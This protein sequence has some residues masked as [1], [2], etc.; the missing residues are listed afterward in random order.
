VL[1]INVKQLRS[2]ARSKGRPETKR[3]LSI[4]A[5]AAYRQLQ[6]VFGYH[7][8]HFVPWWD[9]LYHTSPLRGQRQHH[10]I[11]FSR[12]VAHY[13]RIT[14]VIYQQRIYRSLDRKTEILVG[15]I[16]DYEYIDASENSCW[17]PNSLCHC[18]SP[19]ISRP[20]L[21]GCSMRASSIL[22]L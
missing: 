11:I 14:R 18:L 6:S 2:S 5:P 17:P 13:V 15:V 20:R 16:D 3:R 8:V 9:K 12:K 7:P 1:I 10:S 21:T 4:A 19:L 22:S